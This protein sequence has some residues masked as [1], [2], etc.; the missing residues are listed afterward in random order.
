[1]DLEDYLHEEFKKFNVTSPSEKIKFSKTAYD[2]VINSFIQD[3]SDLESSFNIQLDWNLK[4]AL[5]VS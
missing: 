2:L 3:K 5:W 4:E 1:L